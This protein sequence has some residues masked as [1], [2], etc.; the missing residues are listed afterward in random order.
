MC[1]FRINGSNAHNIRVQYMTLTKGLS[2]WIEILDICQSHLDIII[3][4]CFWTVKHLNE[5]CRIIIQ[6]Q[7]QIVSQSAYIAQFHLYRSFW[8]VIYYISSMSISSLIHDQEN[9]A[10]GG[11]HVVCLPYINWVYF[12]QITVKST[13]FEQNLVFF[14]VR[15]WYIDGW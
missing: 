4:T 10:G 15:N 6:N 14:F 7:I 8:N 13:Q 11:Y 3:A 5:I 2:Y 1:S 9:A 12:E